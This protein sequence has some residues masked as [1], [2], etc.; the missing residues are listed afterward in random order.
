MAARR[1]ASAEGS[2][3]SCPSPRR[4]HPATTCDGPRRH[5]QAEPGPAAE[6]LRPR[7][8]RAARRLR[9]RG[10]G[11][12]A[13]DRAP[14]RRR[15]LRADRRRAALAR[16]PA[17]RP[18]DACR[19]SSATR[20]RAARLQ[21]ALIE[22]MARED[23]N[24]VEEARACAALVEELAV[25]KE[26]VGAPPRPI[27]QR[28]L[29]PDPPARAPRPGARPAR[30]RRAQRGPRPGAARR[31]GPGRAPP[32]R[33][34]GG[35]GGLVGP[36]ARAPGE[37]AGRVPAKRERPSCTPTRRRRSAARRTRS[38][39]RSAATS[40]SPPARGGFRVEIRFE[41]I[42]ELLGL[43]GSLRRS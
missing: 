39:G 11:D 43:A 9:R 35:R 37:G 6:E 24:P 42:D 8:A 21:T 32:A 13:A 31:Q 34:R 23:L 27:A 20:T 10:R 25:S 4:A 36:R 19:S 2:P 16:R 18:R 26:E 3:R 15:P 14:A 7:E 41:D 5:D 28:R 22:N 33:P 38:S 17:G 1:P 12:P 40:A 29:E 30:R